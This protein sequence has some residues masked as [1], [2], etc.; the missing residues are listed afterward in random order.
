[1]TVRYCF[2]RCLGFKFLCNT[3]LA[4][5]AGFFKIRECSTVLRMC[6]TFLRIRI[7]LIILMRIRIRILASK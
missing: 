5:A 3:V 1:M 6:I 2:N 4:P 7:Q